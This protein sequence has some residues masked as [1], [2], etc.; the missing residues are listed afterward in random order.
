METGAGGDRTEAIMRPLLA[1]ATALLISAPAYADTIYTGSF[2]GD[3][4]T[5]P[6]SSPGTGDGVVTLSEDGQSLT[7]EFDF[8]GLLSP[9]LDSHI[10]C[11]AALGSNGP[12]AIGFTP[13]GFPLGVTSGVFTATFD[14][15]IDATFNP[16]F[17]TLH[18]GTADGARTALLAGLD[19]GLAYLNIHTTS[20]PPGEIRAQLAEAVPEPATIGL[21]GLGVL[22]LALRRRRVA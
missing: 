2:S 7:V 10:H 9:T 15:S 16:S 14:L 5:A 11:C 6:T 4:E 20:F 8:T 17:L 12:V 13:A 22:G 19:A 18:G 21:L 1:L 3:Q